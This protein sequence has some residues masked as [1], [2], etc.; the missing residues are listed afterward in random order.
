LFE[1]KKKNRKEKEVL[2]NVKRKMKNERIK[3][4]YQL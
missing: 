1:V 2:K 4:K 3:K